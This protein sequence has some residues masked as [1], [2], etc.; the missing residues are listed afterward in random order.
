MRLTRP[1]TITWRFNGAHAN[2][3]EAWG[4]VSICAALRLR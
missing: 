2:T 3:N 4:L 1:S